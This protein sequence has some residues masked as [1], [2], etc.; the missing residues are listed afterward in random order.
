MDLRNLPKWHQKSGQQ[1]CRTSQTLRE[2][3]N[4][5]STLTTHNAMEVTC[6]MNP[7]SHRQRKKLELLAL[8]R[9]LVMHKLWW[10]K[11]TNNKR[12]HRTLNL[13]LM[14]SKHKLS[15]NSQQNRARWKL[16]WLHL[17]QLQSWNLSKWFK[18]LPP[19]KCRCSTRRA[20]I[21]AISIKKVRKILSV[22]PSPSKF[23]NCKCQTLEMV[24][25]MTTQRK[26]VR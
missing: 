17:S 22:W 18:K 12:H 13:S 3:N 2:L 26:S 8:P 20:M 10:T 15:N 5:S 1:S 23:Q 11:I 7:L 19:C 9:V 25:M 6:R 4:Q 24:P 14:L 21:S 16:S